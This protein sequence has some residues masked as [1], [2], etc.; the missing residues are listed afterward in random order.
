MIVLFSCMK[1]ILLS[2]K[3]LFGFYGISTFVGYLTSNPFLWKTF[4]FPDI[5]FSQADLIKLIKISIITDILYTVKCQNSS[6]VNNSVVRVQ[7]QRK[8]ETKTVQFE[9]I[10]FSMSTQFK[11]KYTVYFLVKQF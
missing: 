9:I 10:Q 8:K 2:Y 5:Q 11:C 4:L 3:L 1:H 7:F 6:F